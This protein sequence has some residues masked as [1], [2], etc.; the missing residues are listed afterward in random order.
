MVLNFDGL[1]CLLLEDGH[2][3][4]KDRLNQLDS[5]I[6]DSIEERQ[7]VLAEIEELEHKK[8]LAKEIIS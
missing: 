4:K 5:P 6:K 3:S 7:Q 8:R 1:V 2:I